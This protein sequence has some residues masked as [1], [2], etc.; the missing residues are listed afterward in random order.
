MKIIGG[1][2]TERIMRYTNTS[3]SDSSINTDKMTGEI[4]RAIQNKREIYISSSGE[5]ITEREGNYN[6]TYFNRKVQWLHN[7]N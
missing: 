7:Q 4:V 6:R 2:E 5:K 3:Y 1:A